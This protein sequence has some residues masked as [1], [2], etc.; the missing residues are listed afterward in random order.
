LNTASKLFDVSLDDQ[1]FKQQGKDNTWWETNRGVEYKAIIHGRRTANLDL[2]YL[3]DYSQTIT[4]NI[5]RL[6][7]EPISGGWQDSTCLLQEPVSY[8]QMLNLW[9]SKAWLKWRIRIFVIGGEN[10]DEKYC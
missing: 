5:S 9:I 3:F 1:L 10:V 6:Q 7:H 2:E 8:I 4:I